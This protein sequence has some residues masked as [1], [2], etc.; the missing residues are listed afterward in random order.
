[1]QRMQSTLFW[2]QMLISH[3]SHSSVP[4]SVL[5]TICIQYEKKCIRRST[6][7][8][9]CQPRARIS[10][11]QGSRDNR[12]WQNNLTVRATIRHNKYYVLGSSCK[13]LLYI[14]AMQ[15][16]TFIYLLIYWRLILQPSQPHRVTSALRVLAAMSSMD[17]NQWCF[18]SVMKGDT[19][20]QN[21]YITVHVLITQHQLMI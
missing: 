18:K 17:G 19:D 16:S 12:R 9:L 7:C 21:N 3:S 15:S 2:R 14:C 5:T 4:K 10:F 13:Q 1:M 6:G 11:Q 8:F 20:L